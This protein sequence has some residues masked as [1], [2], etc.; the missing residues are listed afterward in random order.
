MFKYIICMLLIIKNNCQHIDPKLQL[1]IYNVVNKSNLEYEVRINSFLDNF[2]LQLDD[3]THKYKILQQNTLDIQD[4][5]TNKTLTELPDVINKY[6]H[7][8]SSFDNFTLQL[9]DMTNKYEVLQQNALDMK[10]LITNK[11]LTELPDVINKYVNQAIENLRE[12][13][14]QNFTKTYQKVFRETLN[15]DYNSFKIDIDQMIKNTSQNLNTLL[16]TKFL[17]LHLR[18]PEKLKEQGNIYMK[19]ALQ[20]LENTIDT[21]TFGLQSN[22]SSIINTYMNKKTE[23]LSN[24]WKN[25]STIIYNHNDNCE[26][27]CLVQ[28][29]LLPINNTK[30]NLDMLRNN[31][32]IPNHWKHI[33]TLNKAYVH[34]S[35]VNIEITLINHTFYL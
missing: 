24:S 16:D 4:L 33:W 14:V 26:I 3:M 22:M 11:T 7:I 2:T 15:K 35:E 13:V 17:E 10:D 21:I 6:T 32:T 12:S 5:I 31:T 29:I 25:R 9:H 18:I 19:D 1:W 34:N 20:K 28:N 27:H 8:N 23:Q 30:C